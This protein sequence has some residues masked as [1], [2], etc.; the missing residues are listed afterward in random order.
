MNVSE[1]LV[2]KLVNF[3]VNTAFQLLEEDQCS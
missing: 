2:K 1:F 3:G